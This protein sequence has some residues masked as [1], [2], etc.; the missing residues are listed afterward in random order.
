M[1]QL[2]DQAQ[3]CLASLSQETLWTSSAQVYIMFPNVLADGK[4]PFVRA[5][6]QGCAWKV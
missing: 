3:K 6:A 1:C 2:E 4:S 5:A